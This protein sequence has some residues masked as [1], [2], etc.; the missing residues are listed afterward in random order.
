MA[1][2]EEVV[3]VRGSFSRAVESRQ[4]WSEDE[5]IV[6]RRVA[7]CGGEYAHCR[8]MTRAV[9]SRVNL[10]VDGTLKPA[11]GAAV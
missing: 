6:A 3:M 8:K 7:G 5:E 11:P 4:S 2:Y 10:L 1:G 9:S